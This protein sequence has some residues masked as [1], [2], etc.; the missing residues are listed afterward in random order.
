ML[1]L[2]HN[3]MSSCAQKVRMALAEKGLEWSGHHL[4]LR[5]GDTLTP[6]YLKMN[7]NGVVPT[8]IDDG[9]VIIESTVINEYIDDAYPDPPL[10]PTDPRDRAAMRLWT[11]KLD[12]GLHNHTATISSAI[13]FRHQFA[14]HTPEQ[15]AKLLAAMPD[16]AKR[17]RRKDLLENGV[18]SKLFPAAI[19]AWNKTLGDMEDRLAESAWLAGD[20]FS[21]A[22]IAYAPYLTRWEHLQLVGLVAGRPHL[23]AWFERIRERESYGIGFTDWFN[24]KYLP[25]ME[26]KGLEAWPEVKTML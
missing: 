18:R 1:E 17:E 6:E 3:D 26:E 19:G 15:M 8:I 9:W 13:A 24:D 11:K 23:A 22:D 14:R 12:E 25:L 21:L 7:P 10:R 4:D 5:A 20:E 2:Y 16:P